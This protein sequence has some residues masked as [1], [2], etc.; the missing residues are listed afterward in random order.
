MKPKVV[1]T[2]MGVV[3]CLGDTL[4][5]LEQSV[6][7]ARSGIGEISWI[8]PGQFRNHRGGEVHGA[9]PGA[10]SSGRCSAFAMRAAEAALRQAGLVPGSA[11][12][13]RVGICLGTNFGDLEA[14]ED[15]YGS[16]GREGAGRDPSSR[17]FHE[18][19]T[20]LADELGLGGP[21]LTCSTACASGVNAIGVGFDL[22]RYGR[23]DAMIVGGYDE[24]SVSNYAGLNALH[25][26]T[27]DTIR[28]FDAG[29]SGTLLGEGAGMLV[30]ETEEA[31]RRR[32]ASILAEVAGYGSNNNAHH[33]TAPHRVGIA[34]V[35]RKA[36]ADAGLD[37]S[38]IDYVNAH[39][40]GTKYNDV[41]ETRALREVL[42]DHAHQVVVTAVKP[43]V[44]HTMGAA[45][46]IEAII[47]IQ[48]LRAGLVPRVLNHRA[49]DAECDLPYAVGPAHGREI[50]V[51]LCNSY[52][53][54][55]NNSAIVLRK[56][57]GARD[58]A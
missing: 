37:A 11:A 41:D 6:A 20:R 29:R 30:L 12:A 36:L 58:D 25:A 10:G 1:V 8:E 28:P 5:Q 56:H 31:A 14:Q 18:L 50:E 53:F 19:T 22:V 9:A 42:G 51:A 26:I 49:T 47:T 34:E 13:E 55:G 3:S 48:A 2:G 35:M 33:L 40:T 45:G 54:G 4:E 38:A 44:G 32:G 7:S 16:R 21:R 52:G 43:Y 27:T 17:D 39:G 57:R 24:M 15:H 46:S 23:A